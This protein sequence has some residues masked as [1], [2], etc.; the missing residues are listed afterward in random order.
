MC[1]DT[2]SM[3]EVAGILDWGSFFIGV[4]FTTGVVIFLDLIRTKRNLLHA[5]EEISELRS[6]VK[7]KKE[8]KKKKSKI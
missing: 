2:H 1:I 5:R 7:I 3:V 6:K 4:V 8:K